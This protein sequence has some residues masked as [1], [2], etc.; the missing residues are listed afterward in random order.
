MLQFCKFTFVIIDDN[1][2]FLRFEAAQCGKSSTIQPI[3]FGFIYLY[4]IIY[5]I[6]T[7]DMT[8]YL[9]I[10]D[11]CRWFSDEQIMGKTNQ[12]QLIYAKPLNLDAFA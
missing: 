6:S 12:F 9:H 10:A 4:M 7:Y 3:E 5:I 1:S 2:I 11:I 8:L